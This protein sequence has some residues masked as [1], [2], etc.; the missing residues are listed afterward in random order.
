MV[1]AIRR[2]ARS[3]RREL[4]TAVFRRQMLPYPEPPPRGAR[5]SIG[6]SNRRWSTRICWRAASD[7]AAERPEQTRFRRRGLVRCRTGHVA[8][9]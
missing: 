9:G 6:E 1:E 5:A 3:I 7:I 4:G 2:C 8:Y